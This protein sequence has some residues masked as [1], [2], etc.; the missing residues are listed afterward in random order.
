MKPKFILLT[1]LLLSAIFTQAATFVVTSNAGRGAGTFAE[2]LQK[3]ADN[4]T[5]EQDNITF[6]L[7]GN[8]DDDH[9]I[10]ITA[11]LLDVTSNVEIE[12]TTQP[13]NTFGVTDAKVCLLWKAYAP[14][15][16]TFLKFTYANNVSIFGLMFYQPY[17]N[18]DGNSE[19][20]AIDFSG[21]F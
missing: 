11:S 5:G 10:L 6:N 1:I 2:A 7:P 9:T 19:I 18:G 21:F 20:H 17:W 16:F 15:I 4:G 8:T 13:G 3:A 14:V 12:G